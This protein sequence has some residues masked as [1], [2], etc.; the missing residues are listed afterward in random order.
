MNEEFEFVDYIDE[1]VIEEHYQ[2]ERLHVIEELRSLKIHATPEVG[3]RHYWLTKARN[4]WREWACLKWLFERSGRQIDYPNL[5]I[6]T[7]KK[8]CHI[9]LEA[10]FLASFDNCD[11][12]EPRSQEYRPECLVCTP[13]SECPACYQKR[14]NVWRPI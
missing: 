13:N 6:E 12:V 3:I 10:C 11:L 14:L 5:D 1:S 9:H 2:S 4:K 8:C 7:V